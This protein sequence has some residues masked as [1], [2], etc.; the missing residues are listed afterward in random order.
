MAE[1]KSTFAILD[2]LLWS[3]AS[4][5]MGFAIFALSQGYSKPL[6]DA[7]GFRQTQT[8][9][10]VAGMEN[11]GPLLDYEVPVLGAPWGLPFEFPIYQWTTLLFKNISNL[12]LEESGRLVSIAFFV[13]TI[14]ALWSLLRRL[15]VGQ[16][17]RLRFLPLLL[18]SP[19]Y[20]FWARTFLIETTALAFSLWYL[21]FG[22]SAFRT[23]HKR[24]SLF[25]SLVS[26]ALAAL[27]KLT[28]FTFYPLALFGIL[29]LTKSISLSRRAGEILPRMFALFFLPFLPS[30]LWSLHASAVRGQIPLA[31]FL[32]NDQLHGWL[33][34]K[35]SQ[36]LV[37]SNWNF[38][39]LERGI[40]DLLGNCSVLVVFLSLGFLSR[41]Y[42]VG[43]ALSILLYLLYPLLF[44]PLFAAHE[45]YQTASG[46]FLLTALYLVLLGVGREKS[47]GLSLILSVAIAAISLNG[48]LQNFLPLTRLVDHSTLEIARSVESHTSENDVVL[49]YGLDWS[50]EIAFYSHRRVVMDRD[51]LPL[52]SE[53]MRETLRKTLGAGRFGAILACGKRLDDREALESRVRYL[54]F[55]PSRVNNL[56]GCR[57]YYEESRG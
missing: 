53:V 37:L 18:L 9:I 40:P 31:R 16:R 19:H 25:M 57:L 45:Y 41:Q 44:L 23:P 1:K 5:S 36:R 42:W 32:K 56:L 28:T 13:L 11:G 35:V 49:L 50:P 26:G 14:A 2:L 55:E 10:S 3:L 33:F 46:V 43:A 54:G 39:L 47:E 7:H 22:V 51:F 8:A 27:V 20:L 4:F 52:E 12:S 24:V 15:D 38:L 17:D 6:L 21:A 29:F 34:G 30:L 48:Y